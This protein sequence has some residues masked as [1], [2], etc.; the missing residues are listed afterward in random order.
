MW[1]P[2][3]GG[4]EATFPSKS[5]KS[6]LFKRNTAE[7]FCSFTYVDGEYRALAPLVPDR[8]EE[9]LVGFVGLMALCKLTGCAAS[10]EIIS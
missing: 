3:L 4:I 8:C 10:K 1:N 5:A 7:R 2:G 9:L 6:A